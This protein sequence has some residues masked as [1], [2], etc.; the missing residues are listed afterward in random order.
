MVCFK[1]VHAS[2]VGFNAAAAPILDRI[3]DAVDA[4]FRPKGIVT[5]HSDHAR[6]GLFPACG[7]AVGVF[8]AAFGACT[9]M[10]DFNTHCIID[11]SGRLYRRH[12]FRFQVDAHRPSIISDVT[13]GI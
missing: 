8:A 12:I 13:G 11:F 4:Q 6:S 10:R 9:V 1:D 7:H 2:D 3:Y 5:G